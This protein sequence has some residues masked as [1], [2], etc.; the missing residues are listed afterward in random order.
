MKANQKGMGLKQLL[1]KETNDAVKESHATL[2][3]DMLA[4]KG[5]KEAVSIFCLLGD[6][7]FKN[8]SD[9]KNLENK[10]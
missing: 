3:L 6:S 1:D 2:Q 5:K 7:S 9:F 8:S 4:V 10:A